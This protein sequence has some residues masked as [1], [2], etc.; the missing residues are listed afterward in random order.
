MKKTD[1]EDLDV[2][3]RFLLANERT[4]LAWIRT[5]L[6]VE[7]GGVALIEVHKQHS[8]IGVSVL[9]LGAI[10]AL[11]GYHRFISADKAIRAHRLPAIGTGPTIQVVTIVIIAIGLSLAQFT[12]LR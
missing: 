12:F 1:A 8:Y 6:A 10:V 4:L 2:D 7:A 11:I 5:S 3:A 9:L